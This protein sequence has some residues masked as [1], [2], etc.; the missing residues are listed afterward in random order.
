V[1][2]LDGSDFKF[3]LTHDEKISSL[4]LLSQDHFSL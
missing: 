2:N 4:S 1:I 3:N